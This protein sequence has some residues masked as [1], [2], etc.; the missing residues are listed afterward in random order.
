ME[1]WYSEFHTGNVKLSVRIN[2]QLFSGESEFQRIDVFESEEFGRFVA[3]D[4]EIVFSDKDEFIY[5]EMVTHVPMTVHPNVKNVLI[6]GGGD[7]GVAREL[8][9]YPQIESIDVVESDKMF[10]DVC[11]EMFPDIAQGLKDERVN[12]Y[13]EDG[14][15]FLR[16]KKARYDLIIN[17][18]TDPLGHTEG[19]FTKEFYGNCYKAL[20]ESGILVNQHESPYYS[21]YA[22][23]MRLAH[24]KIAD[25]FPIVRV[26]QAHI[27]TYP[28]GH[29]LFGF[30][31]KKFDPIKDLDADAWNKRG[32]KTRYYNTELH[33]GSFALP[34][35][36][37]E[38]LG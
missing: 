23:A 35:Y 4:G 12:I 19:L 11:A 5:D 21:V 8:I 1:L 31:S 15:R 16:N 18:S 10:V 14:L 32:L 36:V 26:Y 29:W 20:N 9:H 34:N 3:L 37:L 6:I 2:R 30:A 33:K 13:Y 17:D 28:S 24:K 38:A 22:R 25:F 27:P 7:G